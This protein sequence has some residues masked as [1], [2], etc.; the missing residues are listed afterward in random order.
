[1]LNQH[2]LRKLISECSNLTC[3]MYLYDSSGLV[4]APKKKNIEERI[5]D[6]LKGW[7]FPFPQKT[8]N[9]M[10]TP[11]SEAE[12]ETL[13]NRI[14]E[15]KGVVELDLSQK[16]LSSDAV[17][18]LADFLSREGGNVTS[19]L[20]PC[21]QFFDE[22]TR[23]RLLSAIQQNRIIRNVTGLFHTKIPTRLSPEE[24]T[25]LREYNGKASHLL[26]AKHLIENRESYHDRMKAMKDAIL[27][28]LHNR[29]L[30]RITAND[31]T[32]TVVKVRCQKVH[33]LGWQRKDLF[34]AL[35]ANTHVRE[36]EFTEQDG[37]P[38][39]P[40][41]L[42]KN[43]EGEGFEF[44]E[45]TAS[46]AR[47]KTLWTIRGTD[48]FHPS[49]RRRLG[50]SSLQ[51]QLRK[52]HFNYVMTLLKQPG[53]PA[54]SENSVS[55]SNELPYSPELFLKPCGEGPY[56]YEVDEKM[57]QEFHKV[58]AETTNLNI[59]ILRF[60][61]FQFWYE[62]PYQEGVPSVD[63]VKLNQRFK[64]T[65][66]QICCQIPSSGLTRNT[67]SLMW[68]LMRNGTFTDIIL[69]SIPRPVASKTNLE[70]YDT[71]DSPNMQFALMH[72]LGLS[73][74]IRRELESLFAWKNLYEF[75]WNKGSQFPTP[76]VDLCASYLIPSTSL[77]EDPKLTTSVSKAK[78]CKVPALDAPASRD[79][80]PES[81]ITKLAVEKET[82]LEEACLV[83]FPD[84]PAERALPPLCF[85]A[86][87]RELYL[88]LTKEKPGEELSKIEKEISTPGSC[89]TDFDF[90]NFAQRK[91]S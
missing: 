62:F 59:H 20:L 78:V 86:K 84:Q 25:Y 9:E 40:T 74:R 68:S 66:L 7:E 77:L 88:K 27:E 5:I 23:N 45:Y 71:F 26:L 12:L 53:L 56:D 10:F 43:F 31:P 36:L 38:L 28:Q 42:V 64:S 37:N 75:R 87:T 58:M 81:A 89:T 35:G 21:R 19:L 44:D 54:A 34:Y 46:L 55:D 39:Q 83:D 4:S 30:A 60:E 61:P 8:L 80:K 49:Q 51:E 1:M 91:F 69:S 32:L 16:I 90:R 65:L 82:F 63:P 70:F 18:Y 52:N 11:L 24:E 41:N 76:I 33:G 48:M 22:S 14:F 50:S 57:L 72:Y 29:M 6:L 17:E 67:E 3:Q 73:H 2:E 85:L 47:N 79:A 15:F 13:A